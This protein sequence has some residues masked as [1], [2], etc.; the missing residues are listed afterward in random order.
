MNVFNMDF[1]MTC[2]FSRETSLYV[3]NMHVNFSNIAVIVVFINV[4]ICDIYYTVAVLFL[5]VHM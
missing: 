1:Y 4:N 3:L 5:Y 2:I